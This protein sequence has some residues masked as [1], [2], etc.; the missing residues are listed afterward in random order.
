MAQGRIRRGPGRGSCFASA[1]GWGERGRG[2]LGTQGS[3]GG[4]AGKE[5]ARMCLNN[6]IIADQSEL[7]SQATCLTCPQ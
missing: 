5:K 6:E 1:N 3:G 4:V 2:K 7:L